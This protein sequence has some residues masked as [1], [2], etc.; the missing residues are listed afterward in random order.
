MQLHLHGAFHLGGLRNDVGSWHAGGDPSC[1]GNNTLTSLQTIPQG[2]KKTV[3]DE[4][5][6]P[7]TRATIHWCL[8]A[9]VLS[10]FCWKTLPSHDIKHLHPGTAFSTL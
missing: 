3:V 5:S 7:R 4:M 1:I 8:P 9:E 10:Y 2:S 6:D